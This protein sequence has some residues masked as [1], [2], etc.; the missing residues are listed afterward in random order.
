VKLELPKSGLHIEG[1]RLRIQRPELP[2]IEL[3]ARLL[4]DVQAEKDRGG[5]AVAVG[6]A[7]TGMTGV[8]AAFLGGAAV[9]VPALLGLLT[10]A[11]AAHWMNGQGAGRLLL[12]LGRLRV[13]LQVADGP[14]AAARAAAALAPWTRGAPL[15]DPDAYEDLQRRLEAALA[16]RP[17]P[18]GDDQ[19]VI[20]I[21]V[22]RERVRVEG[23]ELHIGGKSVPIQTVKQLAQVGDNLPLGPN[24]ALQAALALLVV[25]AEE[26]RSAVEDPQ[27][28][29]ARLAEYERW[30][31]RLP[32]R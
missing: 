8:A 22:G 16:N 15:A 3:D 4:D 17:P 27:V 10:T 29:R 21:S 24:V 7:A 6:L 19:D 30:S 14:T 9:A 28:L 25:A 20:A 5:L 2:V 26:R 18:G 11:R 32:G 12:T 31:G 1:S 13:G 23:D